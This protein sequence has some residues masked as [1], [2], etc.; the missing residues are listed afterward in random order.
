MKQYA[1]LH[2]CNRTYFILPFLLVFFF[3]FFFFFFMVGLEFELRALCLQSRLESYF[4]SILFWLVWRWSLSNYLPGWLRTIILLISASQVASI[5]GVSH[6]HRLLPCLL[7][8]SRGWVNWW[9]H[10][11][12]AQVHCMMFTLWQSGPMWYVE[13]C[14]LLLSNACQYIYLASLP[15]NFFHCCS[16]HFLDSEK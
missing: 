12:Q 5:T 1:V 10:T 4:Q 6:Q 14:V 15:S 11:I 2:Q 9:T 16:S 7:I 8:A 3:F 13:V